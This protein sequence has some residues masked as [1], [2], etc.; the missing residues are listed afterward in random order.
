M[1]GLLGRLDYPPVWLGLFMALAWPLALLWAPLGWTIGWLGVGLIVAAVALAVWAALEFRRART[2]IVP[3]QEPTALVSGG[4]YRFSRNPIYLADLAILAGWSL[5]LGTPLGLLLL[6]PLGHML[7]RRFI[8][9]E[10]R[11]LE[12]RPGGAFAR[13]RSRV[14]R[15]L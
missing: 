9:P 5:W 3:R 11:L 8:R 2:T 6:W 10:E 14:R 13:Y 12:Q 7:E 15:W 4:P 1:N